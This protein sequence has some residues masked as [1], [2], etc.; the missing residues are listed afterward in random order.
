MTTKRTLLAILL[1]V[2]FAG[3]LLAGE[4]AR[5]IVILKH[6]TGAAPDVASLGGTIESRQDEQLV[7]SIAAEGAAKLKADPAVLYME[8]VGGEPEPLEPPLMG[9][10]AEP[11]PGAAGAPWRLSPH[12]LGSTPWTSGTYSYD[13][14]GNITAIGSDSYVY[15]GVQRLKQS[16]TS[17][18]G[19]DVHLRRLWEHG[20]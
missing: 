2:V 20:D 9:T 11:G 8:R 13:G 4:P 6:R 12:P 1:A 19:G 3:P 17:G 15:D 10:P 16:S 14:A 18:T 7:V 5:Y